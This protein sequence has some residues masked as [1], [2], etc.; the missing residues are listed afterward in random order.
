MFPALARR[1][2]ASVVGHSRLTHDTWADLGHDWSVV[3][4]PARA[5]EPP[6]KVYLPRS[7]DDVVRAMREARTLGHRVVVRGAGHSSN[8]LVTDPGGAVLLTS[9]MDR[10]LDVDPDAGTVTVQPGVA[11]VAVDELLAEQGRGLQVVPD[12]GDITVGGF[13]SVGGLGPT[14]LHDGMFVDAVLALEYVTPDGEVRRCDREHGRPELLRVLAGLGRHGV[15][16]RVTLRTVAADKRG[17]VL[18]NRRRRFRDAGAFVA[19]ATRAIADPGAA[20][21]LRASWLQLPLRPDAGV[22][23]LSAY[24]PTSSGPVT[25]LRA[26]SSYAVLRGL[27]RMSTVLPGGAGVAAKYAATAGLMWAPGHATGLDV[28]RFSDGVL[29]WTVGEPARLLVALAPVESAPAVFTAMLDAALD[30]RDRGSAITFVSI[31]LKGIR[32]DY[33]SGD[34]PGRV[35][36]EL[37]MVVGVDG[38]PSSPDAVTGLADRVDA[39]CLEHGGLRYM[40]TLTRGGSRLDPHDRYAPAAV[41]A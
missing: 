38:H 34:A 3:A 29:D 2:G 11:V 8:G 41:G 26:R 9:G 14:S 5:P 31:H 32:S 30:V 28:Q 35:W 18:R 17:T 24:E 12:H 1:R 21:A 40:H 39:I 15:I 19:A 7:T 20:L 6:S 16:T 4:D 36:V 10:V 27:G 13:A 22:G 23:V 37:L 33:L 25:R